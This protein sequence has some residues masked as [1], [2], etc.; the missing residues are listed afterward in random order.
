[1]LKNFIVQWWRLEWKKERV[2]E[3]SMRFDKQGKWWKTYAT[4]FRGT[5]ISLRRPCNMTGWPCG[6][7]YSWPLGLVVSCVLRLT[8][9]AML[10]VLAVLEVLAVCT[11]P[12]ELFHLEFSTAV[13]WKSHGTLLISD[14]TQSIASIL[15]IAGHP[16]YAQRPQ[17]NQTDSGSHFMRFVGCKFLDLNWKNL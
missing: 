2:I 16:C 7:L 14:F 11:D 5:W 6:A 13:Q 8:V 9:L 17:Y 3:D 10:A 15:P 4:D 1:M 12:P